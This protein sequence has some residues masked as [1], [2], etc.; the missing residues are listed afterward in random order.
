MFRSRV[1]RETYRLASIIAIALIRLAL[2][3]IQARLVA[4]SV[5]HPSLV[6]KPFHVAQQACYYQIF[7]VSRE[8]L[9]VRETSSL[10]FVYVVLS[11]VLFPDS[12][13]PIPVFHVKHTASLVSWPLLSSDS[14]CQLFELVPLCHLCF[15]ASPQTCSCCLT[16]LLLPDHLC[17][18]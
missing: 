1:P 7:C 8:T 4:S 2:S 13:S 9:P 5:L 3:V 12:I 17:S 16:I 11:P 6:V 18:T 14:L 15:I 10:L